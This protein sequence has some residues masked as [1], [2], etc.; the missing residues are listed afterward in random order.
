MALIFSAIAPSSG[1]KKQ[2]AKGEQPVPT[3]KR[4]LPFT[5]F[6]WQIVAGCLWARPEK[7]IV[8]IYIEM[9]NCKL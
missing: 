1:I 8:I 5:L 4:S 3:G 6:Y 7:I 9:V 2:Q